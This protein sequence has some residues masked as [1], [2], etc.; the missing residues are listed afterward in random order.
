MKN[1]VNNRIQIDSLRQYDIK[2]KYNMH[3]QNKV[4]NAGSNG[5]ISLKAN[6]YYLNPEFLY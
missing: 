6:Q 1:E 4:F 3:L 5:P 2:D